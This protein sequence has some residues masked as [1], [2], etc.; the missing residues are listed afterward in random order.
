MKSHQINALF[1]TGGLI[2][3]AVMFYMFQAKTISQRSKEA[4][5]IGLQQGKD[6]LL[7]DILINYNKADSVYISKDEIKFYFK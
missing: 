4:Y 3:G 7:K 1:F 5:E 6:D 2:I